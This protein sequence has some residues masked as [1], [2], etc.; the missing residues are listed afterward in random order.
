MTLILRT[1]CTYSYPDQAAATSQQ[2]Y[3]Q[4]DRLTRLVAL[5][6]MATAAEPQE[7]EAAE[8][9]LAIREGDLW[10]FFDDARQ[11]PATT[12]QGQLRSVTG[13]ATKT[14]HIIWTEDRSYQRRGVSKK[15]RDRQQRDRVKG[16]GTSE[17][18]EKE[19]RERNK[20]RARSSPM[21][22]ER[23][24]EL[25]KREERPGIRQ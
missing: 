21:H 18:R 14:L 24:D 4:V 25:I 10:V 22:I 9:K 1:L 20:G 15:K 5:A 12:L 8:A 19:G 16:K 7:T 11:L 17:K 2:C 6:R 23:E 13:K 3:L